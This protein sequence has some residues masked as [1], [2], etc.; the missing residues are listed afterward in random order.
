MVQVLS[1]KCEEFE[2]SN[3]ADAS[4]VGGILTLPNVTVYIEPIRKVVKE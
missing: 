1:S 3:T 2:L 4:A